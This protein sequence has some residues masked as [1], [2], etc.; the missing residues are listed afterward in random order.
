MLSVAKTAQF[1][2]I[3]ILVGVSFLQLGFTQSGIQNRYGAIYFL[4]VGQ[5]FGHSLAST[6]T[7]AEERAVFLR[8]KAS[9]SYSLLPFFLAKSTVEFPM[10]AIITFLQSLIVYYLMGFQPDFVHFLI[11]FLI[12]FVQGLVGQSIGVCVSSVVDSKE[13]GGV[14]APVSFA[15]FILF[16]PYAITSSSV[17]NYYIWIKVL[18]PFW[19]SMQAMAINEFDGLTLTCSADELAQTVG[20]QC[21]Y[22]TGR[23]ALK[24]YDISANDMWSSIGILIAITVG[25]RIIAFCALK[26]RSRHVGAN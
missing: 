22:T 14:L 2:T 3:A 9:R 18:S 6:L 23:A 5:V 16:T 7:F 17:P 1:F 19:W 20:G 15:P 11:F 26:L 8:E 12:M 25:L 24:A 21:P 4:V 13:L 10:D